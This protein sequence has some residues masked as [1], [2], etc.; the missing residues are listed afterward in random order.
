MTPINTWLGYKTHYPDSEL[1]ISSPELRSFTSTSNSLNVLPAGVRQKR[2]GEVEEV[3]SWKSAVFLIRTFLSVVRVKRDKS[4]LETNLGSPS[5]L[6]GSVATGKSARK[7][8]I[9]WP[10][11]A[12]L[13]GSR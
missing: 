12:Y 8:G 11:E 3:N 5:S 7:L 1:E 13:I 4:R 2:R 9:L 6:W 10:S